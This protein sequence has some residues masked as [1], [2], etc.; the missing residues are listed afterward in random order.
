MVIDIESPEILALIEQVSRITG[1]DAETV[2]QVS[3][4]EILKRL[5]AEEAAAEQHAQND[6]PEEKSQ[7]PLP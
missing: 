2:V 4:V 5:D 1:E 3:V 7:E 6:A